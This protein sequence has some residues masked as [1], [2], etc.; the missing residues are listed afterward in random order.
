MDP[1]NRRRC[2]RGAGSPI[3]LDESIRLGV[4]LPRLLG[5]ERV[6]AHTSA[7]VPGPRAPRGDKRCSL[8]QFDVA[9]APISY[10][11]PVISAD[12]LHSPYRGT[13]I[14]HIRAKVISRKG[15][16]SCKEVVG[17]KMSLF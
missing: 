10:E 16:S 14:R 5:E 2:P 4:C 12:D 15:R 17:Y 7:R 1:T 9:R 8:S 6:R 13:I 3:L 11:V